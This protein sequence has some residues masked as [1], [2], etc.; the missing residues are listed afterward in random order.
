MMM[1]QAFWE[2]V[3]IINFLNSFLEGRG[4]KQNI[5]KERLNDPKIG[6]SLLEIEEKKSSENPIRNSTC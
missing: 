3:Q 4:Q 1:P 2:R 5:E 6:V